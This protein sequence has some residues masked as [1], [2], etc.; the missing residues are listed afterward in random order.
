MFA[1]I[2][3][4]LCVAF[5]TT[6]SS[7]AFGGGSTFMLDRFGMH[8]DGNSFH[9]LSAVFFSGGPGLTCGGTGLAD[10]DY[11][12]AVTD[13]AGTVLLSPDPLSERRVRVIGGVVA[14]YLG[15]T[16]VI[17]MGAPCGG[18]YV[19]TAPTLPTPYPSNEYKLW[20]T[21]VADY[22]PL[23]SGV[24]GFDPG[25]CKSDNFR[26][27]MSPPQT[28]VR[29]HKFY[30]FDRDGVWDAT[31]NAV[32]G[33]RVELYENGV[34]DGVTF[35]DEDGT[36]LFIR[37][38][39]DSGYEVRERSPDGFVN[40]GTPGATWFA[41]T[42]RSGRVRSANEYVAGPEF[43]NVVYELAAGS[44]RT[45]DYWIEHVP[46]SPRASELLRPSDPAWRLALASRNGAPVNLRT[47]IST[48]LPL[49][50]IFTLP[51]PPPG[52]PPG[53]PTSGD[54]AFLDAFSRWHAYVIQAAHDHAG[55]L[56]SRQVAATLLNQQFGFMQGSILIDRNLDGVLVS[57]EDMLDGVIAMLSETGA[58]RTGPND[59]FQDLRHRM[60]M[61]TN[62]F[63]RINETG[64]PGAVQV[65]YSEKP[66]ETR[67]RSP[68]VAVGQ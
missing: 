19:H 50:S 32:G 11:Y 67:V 29:G 51:V 12:F 14:Q 10:G 15:T 16:H 52:L 39:D 38:R 2:A 56:L 45:I 59:P 62:E 21:R 54:L 64:D 13:P 7:L 8:R 22:D 68:Y 55:F 18:I 30:D 65:V 41:T 26:I 5:I 37:G 47:P 4:S 20:L 66:A 34:L 44:G 36:Y 48:S 43:G 42:A 28:I 53:W 61:C 27:I 31:E 23:G 57:L 17:G 60:Q 25:R 35:T 40:D 63:G 9:R 49:L 24:F 46:G 6:A 3:L 33:W 1:R 58:G